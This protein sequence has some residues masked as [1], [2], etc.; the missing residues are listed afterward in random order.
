MAP[1]W[2]FSCKPKHVGAVFFILKCFNNSTF[3]NVVCISWKMKCWIIFLQILLWSFQQL[4]KEFLINIRWCTEKTTLFTT[5]LS[6]FLRPLHISEVS[7]AH[8]QEV[9]PYVYNNRYL[10]FFL[11]ECLLWIVNP[12]RTTDSHLKRIISTDCCIHTVVPPDYGP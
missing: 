5:F 1:W 3:F 8:N 2:W 6:I 10:S 12:T 7:L 4:I 11:D 9:Q